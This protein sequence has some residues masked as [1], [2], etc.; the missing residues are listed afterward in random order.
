MG[1]GKVMDLD[2]SSWE[3]TV[4]KGEKPVVVMFYSDM[5]PYCKQME[6]SFFEYAEEFKEKVIFGRVNVINSPTIPHRYGVMGTPTFKFFCRGKPIYELTG[7][8]YPSLIKK[9]VEE[10]LEYGE[11][12]VK[13]TTWH[14]PEITGYG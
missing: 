9:A 2:Y 3:T 5:C 1:Q 10:N 6:P 13:N 14:A 7:A 8:I 4:E 12:C 11:R